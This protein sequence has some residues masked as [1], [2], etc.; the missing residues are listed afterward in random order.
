MISVMLFFLY[1]LCVT[2]PYFFGGYSDLYARNNGDITKINPGEGLW[3]HK[4]P[5]LSEVTYAFDILGL[6]DVSLILCAVLIAVWRVEGKVLFCTKAIFIILICLCIR[7][8]NLM[9]GVINRV[10]E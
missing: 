10:L 2:I 5:I 7:N 8:M 9:L 6:W 4:L 1:N 3:I